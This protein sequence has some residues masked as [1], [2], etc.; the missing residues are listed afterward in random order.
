M[1]IIL[2]FSRVIKFTFQNILRNF[3]LSFITMTVFLLTLVTINSVL[4]INVVADSVLESVEKKVEV[5]VY[6]TP[7][8]S[9]DITKAAQGYLRGFSQVRDVQYISAEDALATFQERH[10]FDDVILSSLNEIGDNPFGNALVISAMSTNDFDF[11]LEALETPEFSPYIRDKD[12]DDYQTIIEKINALSLRI[13]IAG[14]ALAA[15]FGLIA[16]LIIFNT[17]RV[18]IYVHRDEIGIM[19]L[20]GAND[21]FA[22]GPFLLEAILYS[23]V[24]V[25]MMIIIM[26]IFLTASETSLMNYFDE[27]YNSVYQYFLNNSLIIFGAQFLGLAILSILTTAYAMR[28][29]LRV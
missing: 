23:L 29:Y 7:E 22:R 20:V 18:A 24:A 25:I 21:W 11:I 12:F 26:F 5:T 14:F 13:R 8:A 1:S 6:F 9:E 27:S 10:A 3:W 2:S 17:I 4:F 28:K 16:V 15:L 19:K